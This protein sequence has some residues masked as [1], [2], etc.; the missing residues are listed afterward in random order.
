[1]VGPRRTAPIGTIL[2]RLSL[3]PD[4]GQ[5]K[6]I[7]FRSSGRLTL[8]VEVEFQ[9][10]DSASFNLASRAPEIMQRVADVP[11][12]T[13]EFYLSTVEINSA[14]CTDVHEVREDLGQTIS[15][16]SAVA[17]DV[18]VRLSTTGCH[19]FARYADCIITPTPRY[20]DLIDRNRWLTRRMTVFG[21]HVHIGMGSGDECI[22]FNN[23]FLHFLPHLLALSASSPFW[24]GEDTGL[25]SCRPT[26]YEALPTAGQPYM[27]ESWREFEHLCQTLMACNAI[28]SLKDLW[29]DLRPSPKIGTLEIRICD[30]LATMSET[31]AVVAFV[32]GLAHWF[33]DHEGWLDQVP[34]P[35]RWLAREN[36]WRA[37]R[38]GLDADLITDLD[39]AVVPLRE[40][41]AAWCD[42]I[43]GNIAA[44]GYE[45]YFET[46]Q[47][48]L[49][50]GNSSMRQREVAQRKGSLRDVV[51]HNVA[52]F[53][54]GTPIWA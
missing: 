7:D 51:A 6:M 30:G 1:M 21:M 46:L 24:Q 41:I 2:E 15:R 54:A 43:S 22:R 35:P 33:R 34:P 23:F 14:K 5:Q 3:R 47:Q 10:I 48:I 53:E 17:N 13:E 20:H 36:K 25:A 12:I 52:E 8:G 26:T 31:L 42:R 28:Q 19:P 18:G 9:L 27:V 29:W 37:M 39:G 38:F 4:P 44:L 32:H 11:S 49:S 40:D 45:P 16:L 50:R